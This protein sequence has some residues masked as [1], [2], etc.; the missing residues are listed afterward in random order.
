MMRSTL[1]A[2]FVILTGCATVDGFL[3]GPQ[4]QAAVAV[5]AQS[6]VPAQNPGTVNGM[7]PLDMVEDVELSE[8]QR[9]ITGTCGMED[10]QHLVGR[11]RTSVSVRDIPDNFLVLGPQSPDPL[12]YQS[13]RLTIRIDARDRIE[14]LICG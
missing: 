1:L 8:V 10:L 9:P 6:A 3:P 7:P 12:V 4:A 11:R 14:S 13:D 5:P 2:G